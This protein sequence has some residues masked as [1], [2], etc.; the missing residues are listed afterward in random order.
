ME[1]HIKERILGSTIL[2]GGGIMLS[3]MLFRT[4]TTNIDADQDTILVTN[5]QVEENTDS[6]T[7]SNLTADYETEQKLLAKKRQQR[8][9]QEAKREAEI[10]ALIKQSADAR[11]KALDKAKKESAEAAKK[12]AADN[13]KILNEVKKTAKQLEAYNIKR[14]KAIQEQD[15]ENKRQKEIAK[16]EQLARKKQAFVDAKQALTK[17]RKQA[18][19]SDAKYAVQVA[20]A[21]N[22]ANAN[23]LVQKLK[24]NGYKVT[25]SKTSR[26]VRVIVGPE[27]GEKTAYALREKLQADSRVNITGA[28][29]AKYDRVTQK[30][31]SKPASDAKEKTTAV[32][33]K[34][35]K[36]ESKDKIA[37]LINQQKPDKYDYGV[38]VALAGD[39]NSR[40]ALIAKLQ[41]NGYK[42]RTSHTSR[43]TR[44]IVGKGLNKQEAM[45]LQAKVNNDKRIGVSGAWIKRERK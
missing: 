43:G 32:A 8:E 20:L 25:T 15:A 33:Q 2:L 3:A 31:N 40:D 7:L 27:R 9:R 14:K 4:D 37:E 17:Q 16:K 29:V 41:K 35:K 45:K 11:S 10:K 1:N 34:P 39:P 22:E 28:W 19:S 42:V 44:I 36:G 24:N 30:T 23:R 5:Q 26:G 13:H 12:Q 6:T 38:Q 21:A 18:S